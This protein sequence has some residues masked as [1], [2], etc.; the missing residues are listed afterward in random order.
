MSRYQIYI[1]ICIELPIN[2]IAVLFFS[3]LVYLAFTLLAMEKVSTMRPEPAMRVCLAPDTQN[4]NYLLWGSDANGDSV[5]RHTLGR[6]EYTVMQVKHSVRALLA[7]LVGI[8]NKASFTEY[9]QSRSYLLPVDVPTFARTAQDEGKLSYCFFCL[10]LCYKRCAG[11]CFYFFCAC[12]L[13]A[14]EACLCGLARK[15]FK[16]AEESSDESDDEEA[17]GLLTQ[18]EMQTLAAMSSQVRR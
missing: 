14:W 17:A 8:F 9:R 18:Q 13:W 3:L 11:S 2:R 5:Y 12:F 15:T 16:Q 7:P 4:G 6:I 1:Y 10:A